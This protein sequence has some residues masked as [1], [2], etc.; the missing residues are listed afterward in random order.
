M[1]FWFLRKNTGGR[2]HYFSVSVLLMPIIALVGLILAL[3]LPLI[4]R[5]R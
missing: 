1:S 5:C 2:R 3:L 4:A